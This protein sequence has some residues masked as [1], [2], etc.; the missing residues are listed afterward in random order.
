MYTQQSYGSIFGE[1]R[2]GYN[3]LFVIVFKKTWYLVDNYDKQNEIMLMFK[4]I[5]F[6]YMLKHEMQ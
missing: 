5:K 6:M 1:F 4:Y 3:N 2:G